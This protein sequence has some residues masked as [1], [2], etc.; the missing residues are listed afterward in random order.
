M[1]M[2]GSS[3]GTEIKNA[4]IAAEL[5]VDD[6][7]VEAIWQVIAGAIV[8]HI[9]ANATISTTV[10]AGIVVQVTPATGTGATTAPGS[11]TGSIA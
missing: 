7:S 10:A 8:T 3:L 5:A 1:A 4:L 11:G 9:Q 6:P 2:N